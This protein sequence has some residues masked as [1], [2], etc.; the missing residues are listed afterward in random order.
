MR[1]RLRVVLGTAIA[2]AALMLVPLGTAAQGPTPITFKL[3]IA[4]PYSNQ[5]T[6][7]VHINMPVVPQDRILCVAPGGSSAPV[8]ASG[9]TYS[10]VYQASEWPTHSYWYERI[11]SGKVAQ[12]FL[13]G[14]VSLGHP[15][16]VRATYTYA[17][18]TAPV[19]ATGFSVAALGAGIGL[20][21]IVL[22]LLLVAG[23]RSPRLAGARGAQK[24]QPDR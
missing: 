4:G 10:V 13:P 12:T 1:S 15:T 24:A 21:L 8:C 22:G 18:T 23:S 19:P 16:T 7:A 20:G 14:T 3:T 9:H 5:D 2:G 11:R 17:G 6:F